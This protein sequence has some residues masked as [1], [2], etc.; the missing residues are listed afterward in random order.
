[1]E[2][3]S[4]GKRNERGRPLPLYTKYN[5][6]RLAE[7]FIDTGITGLRGLAV[8]YSKRSGAPALIAMID[9]VEGGG[10]KTWYNQIES[11]TEAYGKWKSLMPK[12]NTSKARESRKPG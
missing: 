11:R 1:M 12:A 4:S 3:Y 10:A 5:D 6:M 7:N 8:D 9:I 2:I